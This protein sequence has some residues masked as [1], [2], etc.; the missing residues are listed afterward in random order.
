MC[1]QCSMASDDTLLWDS[2]CQGPG[3]TTLNGYNQFC[4]VI[5][6]EE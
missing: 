6:A 3:K 1:S 4:H 5:W 2:M